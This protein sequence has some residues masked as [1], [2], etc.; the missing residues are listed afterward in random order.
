MTGLEKIIREIEDEAAGEVQSVIS[1]AKA[2]AEAML[3]E[4]RAQSDKLTGEIDKNAQAQIRDIES[5]RE[6]AIQLQRRQRILQARQELIAET[7]G[8]AR[9][10]LYTLDEEK[11]FDLVTRLAA[12]SAQP[13]EGEVIFNEKDLGRLPA[14]FEKKLNQALG[15][16]KKLSISKST[17]PVDGGVVLSYGGIEENCSFEAVFN[18]RWDDFSDLVRDTLFN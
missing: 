15:E 13:G 7:I 11:Y 14:G 3:N 18:A 5:S 16:G 9:E 17:R 1:K 12:G 10:S 8:K 2:E 4:A 6:S